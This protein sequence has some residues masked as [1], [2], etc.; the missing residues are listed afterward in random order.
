MLFY[1]RAS[2]NQYYTEN[3]K[4]S[5]KEKK[6]SSRNLR[7]DP[8]ICHYSAFFNVLICIAN[9][10]HSRNSTSQF[11]HKRSIFLPIGGK[12]VQ[13]P[14]LLYLL[15]STFKN[16]KIFFPKNILMILKLIIYSHLRKESI[17]FPWKTCVSEDRFVD[18]VTC[19]YAEFAR[20]NF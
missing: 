15:S 10:E 2:I 1:F 19:G 20:N 5:M 6:S 18:N 16:T 9:N 4:I 7:L 3:L 14:V 13:T 12:C 8:E 17:A 11:S